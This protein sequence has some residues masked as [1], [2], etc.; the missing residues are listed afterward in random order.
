MASEGNIVE[1]LW[2]LV[3]MHRGR[4]Q[5]AVRFR[6][7][8]WLPWLEP[9]GATQ[10]LELG[11]LDTASTSGER[12]ISRDD[13]TVARQA[14]SD[15]PEGLRDL[16]VGVMIWGAGTTNGRAPRYTSAA[17]GD[18]RMPHVL[19]ATRSAVRVGELTR[20]YTEFT[21]RGVGRSFF[22]K[23]FATVDD[24]DAECE[25]ALILDD[26]VLRSVNALGWS[27]REAAGTRR[28]S[29]RYAAYTG[30]M[31]EWA[32]SLSVTAPW[33]EWLLFDLNGHV[34]AQ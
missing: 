10:A 14:L 9:H 16:F 19:E 33:L 12:L 5:T 3:E 15:D 6:P 4:Q 21:L 7:A 25:R 13:L 29:A 34:E 2:P 20:A 31:H 11:A 28:W 17:L 32:G 1:R 8:T 23:W 24:R 22:T 18:T 30:A 27:S 26:R